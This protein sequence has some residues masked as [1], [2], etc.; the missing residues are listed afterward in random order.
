MRFRMM[1][2]LEERPDI[3]QRELAQELGVS[4][5][6]AHYCLNALVEK[7]LVKIR[8][9]TKS[10]HK[11]RY[12]YLLTPAGMAEKSA[13]TGR[14]LQ[15]KWAEYHAL[16]EELEAVEAEIGMLDGELLTE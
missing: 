16:K 7:G 12:A 3:S 2:L 13:L 11:Q 15:R 14:F 4:L 1:R 8:N 6:A 10:D 5:G 9:F